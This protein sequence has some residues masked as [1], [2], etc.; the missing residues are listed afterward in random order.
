SD[1]SVGRSTVY[2]HFY[3]ILI[4]I[5]PAGAG[6]ARTKKLSRAKPQSR[7]ENRK[8]MERQLLESFPN[9][10]TSPDAALHPQGAGEIFGEPGHIAPPLHLS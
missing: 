2:L 3:A 9:P 5:N 7:K 8:S 4:R 10:R 1:F 6:Q